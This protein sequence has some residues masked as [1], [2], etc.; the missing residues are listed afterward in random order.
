MSRTFKDRKELK[1]K[2][3]KLF[4]PLWKKRFEK[5]HYGNNTGNLE[6][7]FCPECKSP[8]DFQNGF[9][10]CPSCHWGNYFPANGLREEDDELEYQFAS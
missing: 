5:D 10:T 9:I 7:E 8:T 6:L 1:S 4:E 3:K 2:R